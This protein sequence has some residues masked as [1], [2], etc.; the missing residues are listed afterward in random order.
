M[1][2][3]V[4]VHAHACTHVSATHIAP[5][6]MRTVKKKVKKKRAGVFRQMG[7]RSWGH[8]EPSSELRLEG[9]GM[10]HIRPWAGL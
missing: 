8:G 5:Q 3:C 1:C 9:R 2:V 4:C 7:Q 6:V 10:S